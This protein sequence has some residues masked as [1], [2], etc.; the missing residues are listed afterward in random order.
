MPTS[1]STLGERHA[2][3]GMII[4][5]LIIQMDKLTVAG[6]LGRLNVIGGFHAC[7][8]NFAKQA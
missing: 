8:D 7:L 1:K 2:G 5:L 6:L 3:N 4:I